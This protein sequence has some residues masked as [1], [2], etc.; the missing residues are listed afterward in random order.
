MAD[1]LYLSYWITGFTEHNMLRFYEKALRLFPVSRLNR[2][3]S[4]LRITPIAVTEPAVFEQAFAPGFTTE[5][6]IAAAQAFRHAD[7]CYQFDTSWDLWQN[8]RDWALQPSRVSLACFGPEFERDLGENLRVDFGVDANFL[9]R[10]DVP[11]ALA[12]AQSNIRSLLKFV[13]DLDDALGAPRRQLW[14]E[15]GESFAERL[16]RLLSEES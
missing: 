13:H 5:D 8:E 11:T 7:C 16:Q 6:V 15:S 3:A 14:T 10:T 12:T 9:P 1:Q 2:N 4:T